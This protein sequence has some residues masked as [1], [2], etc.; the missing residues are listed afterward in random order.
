MSLVTPMKAAAFCLLLA[1]SVLAAPQSLE[2]KY[3]KKLAKRFV[4]YG[5]WESD[6]DVA[7]TRAKKED[8][9]LFVY[10][11]RSYSP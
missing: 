1:S 9:V 3:E 10:F 11:S 5:G 7:R 6:Y 8:K 2:D 4:R